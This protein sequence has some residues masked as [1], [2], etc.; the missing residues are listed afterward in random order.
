MNIATA[1][2]QE[3]KDYVQSGDREQISREFITQIGRLAPRNQT[4]F[5]KVIAVYQACHQELSTAFQ[6]TCC[7]FFVR[8]VSEVKDFVLDN[9]SFSHHRAEILRQQGI[10]LSYFTRRH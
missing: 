7:Q 2:H 3:I 6:K 10:E 4:H 9:R 1:T 5:V 8:S